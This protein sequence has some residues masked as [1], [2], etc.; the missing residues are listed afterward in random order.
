MLLVVCGLTPQDEGNYAGQCRGYGPWHADASVAFVLNFSM[1]KL[2]K[3][4][5]S[6]VML[7]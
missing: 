6:T 2:D 1:E 3:L 5:G 7:L 4:D